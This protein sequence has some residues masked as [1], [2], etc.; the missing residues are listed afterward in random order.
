MRRR[1]FTL[2]LALATSVPR[3]RAQERG[4]QHRIAIVIPA[5]PV[6]SSNDT[7]GRGWG[8][9]FLEELRGL[10]EAEGQNLTIERYSGDG[11][12]SAQRPPQYRSSGL[13]LT[14]S[15]PGSL[16]ASHAREATSPAS[17]G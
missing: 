8:R 10:G 9:V 13:A 1:D 16:Q 14:R 3:A 11:R 17:R 2:G 7:G 6:A 5:G 15:R 4:K 12:Q